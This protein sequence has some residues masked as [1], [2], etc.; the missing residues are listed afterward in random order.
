MNS[1]VLTPTTGQWKWAPDRANR[2][3]K[4]Y[5]RYLGATGGETPLVEY[6]RQAGECLEFIRLSDRGKV[7]NWFPPRDSRIADTIWT[8]VHAYENEKDYATQKHEDL[9]RRVVSASTEAGD[10]VGDFFCGSG[11]TAAA[12]EK[13]A[14]FHGKKGSRLVVVGPINLPLGRLFVEEVVLECRKRGLTRV[15]VLAFEFEMGLLPAVLDEARAKGI[16]LQPKYIPAEVFDK[17]AVEKGQVVFHDVSFVEAVPRYDKKRKLEVSIELVD[18]SV[19]YTQGIAEAAIEGLKAGKSQV[20]CEQGRLIK[21]SKD[22]NG[23]VA[24]EVLTRKW[25]DWVDYWAVDFDYMSRKEIVQMPRA[26]FDQGRLPGAEP[27]QGEITDF[28][29][30]W[31]GGYIFENE[32]Q[33]F[34]TRRDRSLELKSAGHTYAKPGRYTIAVKVVDIFGND[35]M[36]LATVTVG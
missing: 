36:S 24:R 3:V 17:R 35:T 2:A 26:L 22:R 23:V 8:D 27:A 34:R 19:H 30:R 21:V 14:F 13:L 15:D 25:T 9:L 18:F 11:T 1:S 20:L 12:A 4:N 6:W 31:T 16:D 33:S 32:W 29:D 28:E 7:E 5:E 10:L